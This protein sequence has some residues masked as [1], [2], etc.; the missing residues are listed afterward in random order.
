MIVGLH[1]QQEWCDSV[2]VM[3][4][5]LER[6]PEGSDAV[7]LKLAQICLV[8]MQ[9]PAKALEL[10]EETDPQYLAQSQKKMFRKLQA[11]AQRQ[12]DD[13]VLEVD[14]EAW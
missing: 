10:L 12:I 3:A 11:V 9:R 7:R 1:K 5:L 2:P 8:E 13:G 6:F 4:E 14:N